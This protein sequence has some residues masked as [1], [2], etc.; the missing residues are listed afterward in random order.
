MAE[1][2]NKQAE[3]INREKREAGK[4]EEIPHAPPLD[5]IEKELKFNEE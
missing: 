5:W 3:I 1:A 4:D 2:H